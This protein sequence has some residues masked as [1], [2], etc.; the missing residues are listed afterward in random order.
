[1]TAT[2]AS[3]WTN[4]MPLKHVPPPGSSRH[5]ENTRASKLNSAVVA[6]ARSVARTRQAAPRHC[7]RDCVRF[8]TCG[9]MVAACPAGLL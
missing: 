8:V 9:G 6:V 2:R 3:H 4:A 1:M 5:T 7:H